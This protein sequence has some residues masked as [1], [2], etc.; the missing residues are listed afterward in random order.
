MRKTT[1]REGMFETNSSSM[2]SIAIPRAYKEPDEEERRKIIKPYIHTLSGENVLIGDKNTL[3]WYGHGFDVLDSFGAKLDYVVSSLFDSAEEDHY[4][5]FSSVEDFY[6]TA[7]YKT[8]MEAIGVP[9]VD[10]ISIDSIVEIDHQSRGM[11]KELLDW[12]WDSY[13]S[14]VYTLRRVLFDPQIKILIEDDSR[15]THD[16]YERLNYL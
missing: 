11:I 9:E 3:T 2:H 6:E 5:C 10:R 7:L 4:L 12:N 13:D 1:I 16:G 8:L 15:D 14:E